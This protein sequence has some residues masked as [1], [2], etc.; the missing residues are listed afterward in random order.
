MT[1]LLLLLLAGCAV[2]EYAVEKLSPTLAR[3]ARALEAEPDLELAKSAIPATLKQT[4]GLL[5][6]APHDRT[7]LEAAS[8]GSLEYAF[9]PLLDDLES[10]LVKVVRPIYTLQMLGLGM[11]SLALLIVG[12]ADLAVLWLGGHRVMAGAMSVISRT[13]PSIP[14]TWARALAAPWSAT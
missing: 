10:L 5:E 13:W 1:K 6:T 8:Q 4:E 14:L 12:G 11:E 7:L 3:G 9:G 2:R